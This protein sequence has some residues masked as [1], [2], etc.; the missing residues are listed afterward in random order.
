LD[1]NP[2]M[3]LPSSG[4]S[5]PVTGRRPAG[6]PD[7]TLAIRAR[8]AK[9]RKR[10]TRP[11]L[12]VRRCA[13]RM[14]YRFRLHRADLPGTPDLVFPALRKVI[15]VHG[16]FWHQHVCPLGSK[17]PRTRQ[18]YW[19][20]KLARNVARDRI[21][22]AQLEQQGWAVMVVWECET[23]DHQALAPRLRAFL[24]DRPTTRH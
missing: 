8:M 18:E 2:L 12:A 20:P 22:R 16:C 23:A 13:H 11:E 15:L 3:V 6:F 7:V 19:F 24:G 14:G 5:M 17:A 1:I 21:V 4:R 9:I 10:D